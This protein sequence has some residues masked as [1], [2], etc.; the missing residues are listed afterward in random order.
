MFMRFVVLSFCLLMGMCLS[1]VA[2]A[3]P[4]PPCTAEAI[5]QFDFWLGTWRGSWTQ[6]GRTKTAINVISRSHNG[7]VVTEQFREEQPDGLIGTSVSVWNPRAAQWQQSWVDNQGSYLAFLGGVRDGTMILSR[8]AKRGDGKLQRQRMRFTEVTR[9]RFVWLW[10]SQTEGDEAWKTDWRIEYSR[11]DVAPA[12]G[13]LAKFEALAGCWVSIA[14]NREYREHWMRPAGDLMVG[15]VRSIRDGKANSYEAMRIELD[16][17]AT[18]VFVA[19]PK[20]QRETRFRLKQS[21]AQEIVFENAKNDFPQRIIYR[22]T[23]TTLDARIEGSSGEKIKG[24]DFPLKR[25]AC[26]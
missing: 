22:P 17:D 4:A 15:M 21:S 10:E 11:I 8:E 24:I 6:D 18:P 25:V 2:L 3:Q 13:P 20:G 19:T 7:C 9:E 23:T 1:S 26:E 16:S 5:K 14:S 12:G